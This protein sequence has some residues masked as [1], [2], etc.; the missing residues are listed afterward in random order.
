MSVGQTNFTQAIF[1]PDMDVPA[2][3]IDPQGRAAGKR[4]SVYRNNVAVSLSEALETAFPVIRKLVGDDF[5]KAMAG[6]YLRQH[7]P[8]TPLMMFY[9]AE[10]PVFLQGF[11]PAADLG[12]LPDMARLELAM[13]QSYHGA[14]APAINPDLLQSMPP[15]RLMAARMTLAPATQ[16]VQSPWPIHAIWLANMQD[17]APKPQMQPQDVLITRPEFDPIPVALPSGGAAFVHAIAQ[18]QTFADSIGAAGEGFDLTAM[19]GI[20]LSGSA[21]THISDEG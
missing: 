16:L 15:D 1:D 19:L 6:V 14:D 17:D 11:E 2:G 3:L 7:P 21:I 10:M 13:R 18:G 8:S 4:F 12:Y 5:F 9:G 20:L